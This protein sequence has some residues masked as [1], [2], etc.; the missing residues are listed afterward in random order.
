MRDTARP[1]YE[2]REKK[3]DGKSWKARQAGHSTALLQLGVW[4]R[5]KPPAGSGAGPGTF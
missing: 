5:Y 4:G 1:K 2:E 3:D